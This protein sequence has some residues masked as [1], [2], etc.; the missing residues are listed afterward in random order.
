M[1]KHAIII[2]VFFVIIALLLTGCVA[3]NEPI[4]SKETK[5]VT[6]FYPIYIMALNITQNAQ[7]VRLENMTDNQVGCLHNYTLQTT[8]LK[9]IEK[10][11]I[12]I[13]NGL[14]I[15]NF[16]DK[17]T[18]NYPD[19]KIIDT[20]NADLELIEDSEEQNGHVWNS[21]E[22]YKK[23]VN[24]IT[25]QLIALD[26]ANKSIYEANA[27]EY[28]EKI[29]KLEIYRANS[30]EYVISCNEALEYLLTDANFNIIRVYTDHD[31]AS[32]SSGNLAEVIETAKDKNVKAILVDK[33]DNLKNAQ[34]IANETGA[35]VVELDAGLT[36]GQD[37]N[38][39]IEAMT[40]NFAKIKEI[41]EN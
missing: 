41:F 36:G 4:E 29:D 30:Q 1:K 15:E 24:Y 23:Q 5:I 6:S 31:E 40:Y 33:N 20:S 21:I 9:N 27:K 3:K 26:E 38:S 37:K 11:N 7:D 12:F 17:I 35:K 14:G 32:L 8:D 34:L 19:L 16:M 22:N 39:Y 28:L 13:R 25:E 10:A 2:A 18:G